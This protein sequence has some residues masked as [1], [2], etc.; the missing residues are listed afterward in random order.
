MGLCARDAAI[1]LNKPRVKLKNKVST[2]SENKKNV[3]DEDLNDEQLDEVAGGVQ[4]GLIYREGSGKF[5]DTP[6]EEPPQRKP[7]WF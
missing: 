2:M 4:A 5:I 1:L 6:P 7:Q 3:P